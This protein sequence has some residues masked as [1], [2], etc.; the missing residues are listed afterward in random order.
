MVAL[1]S[2]RELRSVTYLY[3]RRSPLADLF[4]CLVS[5]PQVPMGYAF[6]VLGDRQ[7]LSDHPGLIPEISSVS[8]LAAFYLTGPSSPSVRFSPSLGRV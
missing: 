3:G 8:H 2:F 7:A 5:R 6:L 4:S 1:W